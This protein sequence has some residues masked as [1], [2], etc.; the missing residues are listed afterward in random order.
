MPSSSLLD[1]LWSIFKRL[2][3]TL[4]TKEIHPPS[5]KHSPSFFLRLI[6]SCQSWFLLGVQQSSF[7]FG[8]ELSVMSRCHTAWCQQ[9]T[10]SFVKTKIKNKNSRTLTE[11]CCNF[12][13]QTWIA[14]DHNG[15][16]SVFC[17]FE[18]LLPVLFIFRM[19]R[20]THM[21]SCFFCFVLFRALNKFRS[22]IVWLLTIL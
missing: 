15:R 9:C 4:L 17:D 21:A 13:T 16:S 6:V 8:F 14:Y 10:C 1:C 22:L 11:G 20:L 7:H 5:Q 2:S 18:L 3:L 19:S 12:C